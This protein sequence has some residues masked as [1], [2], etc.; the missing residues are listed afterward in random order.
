MTEKAIRNSKIQ[1]KKIVGFQPANEESMFQ[2]DEEIGSS[3]VSS[4][5]PP[6]QYDWFYIGDNHPATLLHIP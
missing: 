2:M 3:F 6:L 5:T 4:Q 1:P